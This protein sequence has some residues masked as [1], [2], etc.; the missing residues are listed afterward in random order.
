MKA[1]IWSRD[2]CPYCVEAKRLLECSNI[3]YE[4]RNISSNTWTKEQLL[5]AVPDAKTVPQIFLGEEYIGGYT[6]LAKQLSTK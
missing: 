2:N 6:D 5:Q 4:E 3:S 1:I